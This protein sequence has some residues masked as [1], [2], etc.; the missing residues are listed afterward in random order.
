ML[1]RTRD[2]KASGLSQE[3]IRMQAQ[4]ATIAFQQ[5]TASRVSQMSNRDIYLYLDEWIFRQNRAQGYVIGLSPRVIV[6]GP[7]SLIEDMFAADKGMNLFRNVLANTA[8]L[9][10]AFFETIATGR[11][12]DNTA[13]SA[14]LAV[15]GT[16]ETAILEEFRRRLFSGSWNYGRNPDLL[17]WVQEEVRHNGPTLQWM[18]RNNPSSL[19]GGLQGLRPPPPSGEPQAH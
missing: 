14:P 8:T 2:L 9:P 13:R 15:E 10:K 16:F 6:H 17:R 5:A 12:T 4:E 1:K 19:Q 7:E 18:Q 3:E 11:I